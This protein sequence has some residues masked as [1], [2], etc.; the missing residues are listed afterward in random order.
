MGRF[1]GGQSPKITKGYVTKDGSRCL[2]REGGQLKTAPS[3]EL[4]SCPEQ[5]S[6]P[7][8]LLSLK[9]YLGM[10]LFS[11]SVFIPSHL[12][13]KFMRLEE[14][15]YCHPCFKDWKT[16]VQSTLTPW[17]LGVEVQGQRNPVPPLHKMHNTMD[18]LLSFSE[19]LT[20]FQVRQ[21]LLV[22]KLHSE[23]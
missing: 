4:L 3:W 12:P 9:N 23:E 16:D 6:G 8:K 5:E 21:M 1:S 10:F 17:W 19:L 20:N 13:H 18:K 11:N 7:W 15:G 22:H 14:R 2:L